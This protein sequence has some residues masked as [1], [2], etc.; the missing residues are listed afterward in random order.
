MTNSTIEFPEH[1]RAGFVNL[2]GNPNVGKSTLMNQLV[3]EKISIMTSKAQ[4]TRHRIKGI[5]NGD[6]FQI[7]YSDLPGVLDPAYMMQKMMMNFV[8]DS[9]QD[10]DIILY[11]IECG[12]TRY[13]EELVE[14]IKNLGTPIVL[15]LNK[16]DRYTEAQVEE[17]RSYWTNIFPDADVFA[18][19]ALKGLNIDALRDRIVALLPECPPYFPKDALTDRPMRFFV[20]ELIREQILLQYKKEIPYSVEVVVDSYKEEEDIIRI[21]ATLFVER[22]TQKAI[23]IGSKGSAIKKLGTEARASIEDFLQK[24]VYLDLSVKVLKDWRNNELQ[25]KK[26]GYDVRD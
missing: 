1:H 2:I 23:I 5:V 18:I 13:N 14:K 16:I 8:V 17:A 22:T 24:H 3:G 15:V 20:S 9:L 26:F 19:S 7:V 4:T 25:M 11:L 10:A 21:G 12:E 6:D